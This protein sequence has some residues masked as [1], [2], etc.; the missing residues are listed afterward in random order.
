MY[1]KLIVILCVLVVISLTTT[2]VFAQKRR[3]SLN[4]KDV[5]FSLGSLDAQ[6]IVTGLGNDTLTLKLTASGTPIVTCTNQGGNQAPGQN[7]PKVSADGTTFVSDG[8]DN[9]HNGRDDF[10]VTA[11][12]AGA[13]LTAKKLGCPNNNW[14]ANI[15]FVFWAD[16]T[17]TIED[18]VGELFR[19]SYNCQTTPPP[20][21]S[22]TCTP[23]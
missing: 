10:G 22:V 17:I 18:N 16:A 8:D 1:R 4:L 7:P 2:V 12:N 19:Q 9:E 6:G 5:S 14:T 23:R 3:S 20:S 11:A 15:D 21:P 13:G